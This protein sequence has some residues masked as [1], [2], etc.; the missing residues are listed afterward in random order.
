MAVIADNRGMTAS[1]LKGSA[2]VNVNTQQ[3]PNTSGTSPAK[4]HPNVTAAVERANGGLAFV[5]VINSN[6]KIQ[7]DM[8]Y[9]INQ[10]SRMNN[11]PVA[12]NDF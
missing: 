12:N 1:T 10:N 6:S 8:S 5:P 3:L 7:S 9:P 2:T 4:M 11:D